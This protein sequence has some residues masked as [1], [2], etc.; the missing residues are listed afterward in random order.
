MCKITAT[1]ILLSNFFTGRITAQDTAHKVSFSLKA[2][3]WGTFVAYPENPQTNRPKYLDINS[4]NARDTLKDSP[5]KHGAYYAVVK[6][7]TTFTPGIR[8][9]I[10]LY[11]E[12]R[13]LSYGMYSRENV[14][15]YPVFFLQVKD[16]VKFLK[17]RFLI[18]GKVGDLIDKRTE[19]GLFIY[20]V[21]AQGGELYISSPGWTTSF[22]WYG[23]FFAGIGL[24]IDDV[25][26]F[27]LKKTLGKKNNTTA[28]IALYGFPPPL[29]RV[30]NHLYYSVYFSHQYDKAKVYAQAGYQSGRN[31]GSF[32]SSGLRQQSAFVAGVNFKYGNNKWSGKT[33]AEV[34][35]YGSSINLL[36]SD[37]RVRYRNP[38]ED[39]Y[40]NTIGKYLYP[41]RKYDNPFSQWAVFTEYAVCDVGAESISGDINYFLT[42]KTKAALEYDLN[43]ITAK[44][45]TDYNSAGITSR[46]FYSFY[47]LGYYYT[48]IDHCNI[49]IIMTNRGM[50]LNLGYPTLH[51][52]TRPYFGFKI[53][54]EI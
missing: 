26:A 54:C 24:N 21:D 36:H 38:D 51:Q 32:Y 42:K 14:V 53:R 17:R 25:Y 16:S 5:I 13:G 20:N 37:S 49:G 29:T 3:F 39:L 9:T 11:G 2:A 12:H 30:F 4:F 41:L 34:R 18:E 19:E 44:E 46:I 33:T 31:K 28:G 43:Y 15:V 45:N 47:T 48:P 6:S 40:A 8:L 50:N 10:N 35:Y 7:T 23:D 52:F 27:S 1:L 22:A